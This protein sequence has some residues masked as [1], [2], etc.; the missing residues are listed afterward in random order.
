MFLTKIK[1]ND[2]RVATIKLLS[3]VEVQHAV[4]EKCFPED[5]T[6]WDDGRIL[7]RLDSEY[8]GH[9]FYLSSP[10][11][12]D[13]T[14]IIEQFGWP[15][16][17]YDDQVKSGSYDSFLSSLKKGQ[18]YG[19]RMT[20]NSVKRDPGSVIGQDGRLKSIVGRGA[21]DLLCDKL[22]KSGFRVDRDTIEQRDERHMKL[23]SHKPSLTCV[24]F[25]GTLIVTDP[26]L[27]SKALKNGIGRAKAF[28]CGMLSLARI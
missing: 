1:L 11:K 16:K 17:T 27:A 23:K 2:A 28:G 8:E 4:I 25:E 14:G 6:D 3:N 13:A 22:E 20:L 15:R 7:W 19:F 18:S 12:P 26:S 21:L 5:K 9:C 10:A 24:T